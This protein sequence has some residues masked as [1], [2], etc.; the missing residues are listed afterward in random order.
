[1]KDVLDNV[2]TEDITAVASAVPIDTEKLRGY[3]RTQEAKALYG[4]YQPFHAAHEARGELLKSWSLPEQKPTGD[5]KKAQVIVSIFQVVQA[6]SYLCFLMLT[7][8]HRLGGAG[9]F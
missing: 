9:V 4:C 6:P 8:M 2:Q 7:E 1:M 5:Y 3:A